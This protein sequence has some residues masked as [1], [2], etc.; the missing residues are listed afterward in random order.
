V[1]ERIKEFLAL[2]PEIVNDP[3]PVTF[4]DIRTFQSSAL[5]PAK[6]DI[7]FDKVTFYYPA[8]PETAAIKNFS[9][10]FEAGK[11]TAIVGE[12]G[13]GKT[14]IF[15]L[16]LRFYKVTEGTIL[17]HGL[18]YS[19]IDLK[20]L[21]SEFAYL[22]QD[23]AIFS[24]SLY[25]NIA[26]SKP[27]VPLSEVTKAADLSAALDFIEKLPKGFDTFVGEKGVRLSGGQKQR[28]AIARAFLKNPNLLLLDEATS[29]LDSHNEELV[30]KGLNT[31]S[32]DRTTIVI[33]HRLSTIQKADKILVMKEGSLVEEGTH[34][35]LMA[36][37]DYYYKLYSKT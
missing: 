11:T 30:Q 9:A 24:A 12:S 1:S 16:L 8:K 22:G 20:V 19:K 4:D 26:Y 37:K 31:L 34:E 33:A 28:I 27:G 29:S 23:P 35:E 25:E 10:R 2:E 14:T 15:Q 13:A 7:I 17:Y 18:D 6:G 5:N 32:K 36:K 3:H 21:R